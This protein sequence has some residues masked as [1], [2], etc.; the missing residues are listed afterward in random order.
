MSRGHSIN[1]YATRND[2]ESVFDDVTS[3]LGVKYA[4]DEWRLEPDFRV[5]ASPLE[6]PDF[7][8]FKWPQYTDTSFFILPVNGELPFKYHE[9]RQAPEKYGFMPTQ[10]GYPPSYQFVIFDPSGFHKSEQWG[11]GMLQGCLSTNSVHP[12]SL[13]IFN[14][15]K[16][17]IRKRF[18]LIGTDYVGAEAAAYLDA[19]GRL[20]RDLKSPKISDLK[21]PDNSEKGK[22][23]RKNDV[24]KF[25][26][27]LALEPPFDLNDRYWY[28]YNLL[29]MAVFAGSY[30]IIE[31]LINQGVEL[32]Q[33]PILAERCS[34][35]H[36]DFQKSH[37]LLMEAVKS[38][39]EGISKVVS[40]H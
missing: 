33:A 19:G 35:L 14:A 29:E 2:Y 4:V 36:K 31:Y 16:K 10:I 40:T 20:N 25:V 30:R 28:G 6:A 24:G 34:M 27:A 39:N 17:S 3:K 18:E 1:H 22:A 12:D 38:R 32:G 26:E 8:F 13:A 37:E 5:Y 15:F 7:A 21:R 9:S 23:L 11:E